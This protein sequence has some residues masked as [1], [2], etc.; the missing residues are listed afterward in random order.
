MADGGVKIPVSVTGAEAAQQMLGQVGQAVENLGAAGQSQAAGAKR[1]GDAAAAEAAQLD[2]L[3][4]EVA[5][6][7]T[8]LEELRQ[9]QDRNDADN[10]NNKKKKGH[11]EAADAL[12]VHRKAEVAFKEVLATVNPELARAADLLFDLVEGA[13]K[14]TPAL[15]AI[16]G[17]GAVLGALVWMFQAIGEAAKRAHDE[18]NRV[19]D[20]MRELLGLRLTAE[21]E[22]LN[23]LTAAGVGAAHLPAAMKTFERLVPRVGPALASDAVTAQQAGSLSDEQIEAFLAGLLQGGGKPVGWPDRVADQKTLIDRVLAAG[24]SELAREELR[25]Y[26]AARAAQSASEALPSQPAQETRDRAINAILS[27][28]DF[29]KRFDEKEIKLMGQMLQWGWA[30][31]TEGERHL[32]D[33]LSWGQKLWVGDETLGGHDRYMDRLRAR[34]LPEMAHPLGEIMDAARELLPAIEKLQKLQEALPGLPLRFN[35][36]N[37]HNSNNMNV[38]TMFQAEDPFRRNQS[39][40]GPEG[41]LDGRVP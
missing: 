3:Q 18:T 5:Q 16:G 25:Q 38:G 19:T 9:Q 10:N 41:L 23:K 12:H 39:V 20:A 33:W 11:E 29:K 35:I 21:M 4:Q 26:E 31:E 17:A 27:N 34:K 14:L 22:L 6:L 37:Y 32:F 24:K 1:A 8:Q 13:M 30:Q 2:K 7:R 15:F 40:N 28:P 36:H